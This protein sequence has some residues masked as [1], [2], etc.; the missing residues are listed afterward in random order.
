MIP[1]LPFKDDMTYSFFIQIILNQS[2]FVFNYM[3]DL[4]IDWRCKGKAGRLI[5]NNSSFLITLM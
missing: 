3:G 2:T 1:L 5:R 4:F